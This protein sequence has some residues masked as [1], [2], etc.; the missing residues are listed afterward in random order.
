MNINEQ[1]RERVIEAI[2]EI[3][4]SQR[5]SYKDIMTSLGDISQV[6]TQIKNGKRYPIFSHI[7]LLNTVYKYSFDWLLLGKTP[8]R[9]GVEKS[10][11]ERIE[12]IEQEVKLLKKVLK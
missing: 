1:V 3:H 8:K 2:D 9:I 12:E 10:P 4:F 5:V 11:L 7:V 6:L